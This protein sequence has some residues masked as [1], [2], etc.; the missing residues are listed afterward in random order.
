M[1]HF[2]NR[3]VQLVAPSPTMTTKP[4]TLR[5]VSKSFHQSASA[6]ALTVSG[7]RPPRDRVVFVV[8]LMYRKQRFHAPSC[9]L[10]VLSFHRLSAWCGYHKSGLVAEL[11]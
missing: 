9:A 5:F 2:C 7:P 11:K 6:K 3:L 10:P 1:T 8:P 4:V